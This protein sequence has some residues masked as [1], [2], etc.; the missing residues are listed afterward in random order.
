MSDKKVGTDHPIAG[1]RRSGRASKAVEPETVET[2]EATSADITGATAKMQELMDKESVG[3]RPIRD[4]NPAELKD[5]KDLVFLGR[6]STIVE[7]GGYKFEIATLTNSEK[8]TVIKE[9][10]S[11]GKEMASF[12]QTCTLAMAIQSINDVPLEE[13]FEGEEDREYSEYERCLLYVDSWQSILVNLLFVEYEKLN[14]ASEGSFTDDPE[15]ED[16]L[17]K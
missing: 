8:R 6:N 13:I 7:M 14:L 17:K 12:V 2:E 5:L 1:G 16:K 11:R 3:K 10:A 4:F 15:G 9:L